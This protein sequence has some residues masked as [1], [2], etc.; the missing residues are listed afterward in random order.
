[1]D[2]K[3]FT[4]VKTDTHD[5]LVFRALSSDLVREY[6]R[7]AGDSNAT[8]TPIPCTEMGNVRKVFSHNIRAFLAWLGLEY[9]PHDPQITDFDAEKYITVETTVIDLLMYIPKSKD[10]VDAYNKILQVTTPSVDQV[11]NDLEDVNKVFSHSAR[12]FLALTHRNLVY[13]PD[14]PVNKPD[15]PVNQ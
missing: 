10:V 6:K 1:L 8:V 11:C 9:N 5:L 14:E 7:I 13:T 2:V 4:E 15:E 3:E 12:A